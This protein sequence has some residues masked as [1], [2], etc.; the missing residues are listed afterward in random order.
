MDELKPC[1]FCGGTDVYIAS[2][3]YGQFSVRCLTCGAV[4]WGKDSED[5]RTRGKNC[6]DLEQEGER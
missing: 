3:R 1:K 5:I 4:V 6:K 2:N